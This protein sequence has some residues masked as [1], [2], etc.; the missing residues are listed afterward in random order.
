MGKKYTTEQIVAIWAPENRYSLWLKI[1]M[2]VCE[3]LSKFGYI[4][5]SKFETIKKKIT[6]KEEWTEKIRSSPNEVLTFLSL[7]Q[8]EFGADK[9]QYFHFGL[10]SG[11][12][13]DTALAIQLKE[14]GEIILNSIGE[15][16]QVIK[17]LAN[18]YRYTPMIGRT[19]GVHA[20]PISFGLKLA[21]WYAEL[22]RDEK[23]M[24]TATE[25]I[26]YGKLSG[27]VGNFAFVEPKV[28]KYVCEKL[29]LKPEPVSSQI[30]P[31]DRQ[32]EFMLTLALVASSL[33]RFATEIRLLQQTEI[34]E[35]EEPFLPEEAGSSSM[36][37]KRNPIQSETICG[38]ARLVRSYAI[39]FLENIVQWGERDATN[40]PSEELVFPLACG[41]VH[42]M[43][44]SFKNVVENMT[45][46]T[47]N[48]EKN[49]YQSGGIVFSQRLLHHLIDAGLSRKEAYDAVQG[50]IMTSW[51]KK[52]SFHE[53]LL[54]DGEMRHYI[55]RDEIENIFQLDVYLRAV[56]DIFD[57]VFGNED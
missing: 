2:A 20:E 29:G 33:D 44:T 3:A 11:D 13:I 50:K 32:A 36:P 51:Q 41:T 7:I 42:Y 18:K 31:R 34:L 39:P 54:K 15:V 10:S 8:E 9:V 38:L 35:L 6:Y 25:N 22:T 19:H 43:L 28:E 52:A 55:T 37:H 56:D 21:S 27:A 12:I 30:I 17:R 26:A 45:V 48:M 53:I 40:V 5:K 57:R 23:R 49:I 47:K 46:Y 14:S 4:P 24:K 16:K 1:E